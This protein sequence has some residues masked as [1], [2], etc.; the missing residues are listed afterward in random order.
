MQAFIALYAVYNFI[1]WN[2][3]FITYICIFVDLF[4]GVAIS[5][6]LHDPT[7]HKMLKGLQHK[8]FVLFVPVIAVI[9]QAFFVVCEL[10][11][12]WTGT[13]QIHQVL[14]VVVLSDFPICLLLCLFV[15]LME[16]YSFLEN[17][18]KINDFALKI[19]KYFNRDLAKRIAQD[20]LDKKLKQF[21]EALSKGS[22]D[23]KGE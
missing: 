16:V 12:T 20:T 19:L 13:E 22:L 15:I 2:A 5:C 11:A 23:K 14:G 18:A 8:L 3:I 17:S 10:P 9:I 1:P 7:S 4:Y 21:G 6:A